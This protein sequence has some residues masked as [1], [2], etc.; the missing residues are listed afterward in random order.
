MDFSPALV[1][2]HLLITFLSS[3]FGSLNR[4]LFK[5]INVGECK[6]LFITDYYKTQN[7]ITNNAM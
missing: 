6:L 1:R 3:V 5:G 7:L 4:K 2:V